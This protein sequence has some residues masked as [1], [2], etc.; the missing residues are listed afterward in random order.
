MKIIYFLDYPFFVGGSNKVLLTQAFIMQQRA[1]SVRVVIPNDAECHH[2]KEYDKICRDY[3]LQTM[4]AYYPVSTCMEEVDIM[5]SI[6]QCDAVANIIEGYTPDLIHSTQ[7]NLAVELAARTLKIPHLMNIYQVD[8]SVFRMKW[9]N[10]YPQYHSADSLLFSE[11]WKN[12]LDISSQCI[13]VAYRGK[14]HKSN[15]RRQDRTDCIRILSIGGLCERKNQ[16]EILRFVLMC[17]KN[18]QCV[19]LVLLGDDQTDYGN[20]CKQF[21]EEN[22]LSE[23]VKFQGFVSDV[24]AFLQNADVLLHASTVESYPGV[25]VESMANRVPVITTAIAG[26]PELLYHRKNAF[27]I[28]GSK[29]ADIYQTFL[30][31]LEYKRSG[32]LLQIIDHAYDTYL[33][34]HTYEAVG[35]ELERY[36]HWIIEDY[37]NKKE[38]RFG[39][40]E[41]KRTFEQFI[42]SRNIDRNDAGMMKCLWFLKHLFASVEEKENKKL[43]IWGAGFWGA[44][45]LEWIRHLG[46]KIEFMGF[47]DTKKTGE[48]LG[49]PIRKDIDDVLAECGTVLVAIADRNNAS[50]V[51]DFLEQCGKQRCIDYFRICYLGD[52][53][54]V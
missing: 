51:M 37:R 3:G 8:P 43:V 25:I 2:A 24:E 19:R 32:Q 52:L 6:K 28:H 12:G 29:S 16:L 39:K 11:C 35:T 17:K 4:E 48:Y 53:I 44:A 20:Q 42:C 30:E 13:R 38:V 33:S 15:K 5:E 27:L 49:A 14:E 10:A 18:R 7:L 23:E 45:A 54:N 36:Y 31:V 47:I 9:M 21:V 50:E 46:E 34:M 41:I 22:G 26:I 1:N 40:N